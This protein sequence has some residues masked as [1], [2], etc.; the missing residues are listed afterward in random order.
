VRH[1]LD[2]EAFTT[3]KLTLCPFSCVQE[4]ASAILW[5]LAD[6][7]EKTNTFLLSFE[8]DDALTKGS[9]FTKKTGLAVLTANL[10]SK[11]AA[12]HCV[13]SEAGAL[14][15]II[16]NS[17][18]GGIFVTDY[19]YPFVLKLIDSSLRSTITGHV[20]G[21]IGRIEEEPST[22]PYAGELFGST[23]FYSHPIKHQK[24][25]EL[26]QLCCSATKVLETMLRVS[27]E[28]IL[29]EAARTKATMLP[30][31]N[32]PNKHIVLYAIRCC[33]FHLQGHPTKCGKLF[34]PEV[35]DKVIA[36]FFDETFPPIQATAFSCMKLALADQ[37]NLVALQ[38]K[39]SALQERIVSCLR[40]PHFQV[41]RKVQH[42]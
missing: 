16:A 30:L 35:Q 40:S 7:Y 42:S 8:V 37:Q 13:E 31:L 18:S 5:G 11:I 14:A 33:S 27:P 4:L 1:T 3:C 22:V 25:R 12:G 9:Y 6:A 20:V 17:T 23:L 19:G 10:S 26:L 38:A 29:D 21:S 2:P 36:F 28:S 15:S 32:Y 24:D 39:I 34:V 41:K